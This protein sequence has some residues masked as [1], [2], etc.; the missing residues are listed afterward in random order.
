MNKYTTIQFFRR[1]GYFEVVI[2]YSKNSLRFRES[3]KVTVL[4]EHLNEG[5]KGKQIS[6][7][8]PSYEADLDRI[9]KVQDG[10]EA[11]IDSYVQTH[12]KKP[13]VDWVR[14]EYDAKAIS[15]SLTTQ[16]NPLTQ[17]SPMQVQNYPLATSEKPDNLFLF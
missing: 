11:I 13:H 5:K 15:K 4:F 3:T 8:H 7:S 10:V 14:K 12:G 6:K 1:K 2:F 16:Q 9:K 17:V